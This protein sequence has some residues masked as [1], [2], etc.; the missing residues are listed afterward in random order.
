MFNKNKKTLNIIVI[1]A[2]LLQTNLKNNRNH[3]NK[4]KFQDHFY[5]D[6][7]DRHRNVHVN[8]LQQR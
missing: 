6:G 8:F 4:I 7:H 3:E 1:G 2:F 5:L